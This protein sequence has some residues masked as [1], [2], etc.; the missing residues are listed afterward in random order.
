MT[1]EFL[2]FVDE[3]TQFGKVFIPVDRLF[4]MFVEKKQLG[5]NHAYGFRL[6]LQKKGIL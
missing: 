6:R 3:Q 1:Q 5:A 2:Q 4:E